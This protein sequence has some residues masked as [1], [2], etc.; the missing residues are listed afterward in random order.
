MATT[1]ASPRP[2]D[3]TSAT[4]KIVNASLYFS[5]RALATAGQINNN[6]ERDEHLRQMNNVHNTINT[7]NFD[8]ATTN[9]N[10][11]SNDDIF[12]SLVPS[13][14]LSIFDTCVE[15][16]QDLVQEINRTNTDDD[17][18][19]NSIKHAIQFLFNENSNINNK[20]HTI[21]LIFL[22]DA[23]LIKGWMREDKNDAI[24]AMK[25]LMTICTTNTSSKIQVRLAQKT[26]TETEECLI[27]EQ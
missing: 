6:T 2:A 8:T 19:L 25:H 14:A 20:T 3:T 7:Y 13:W 18:S 21:A 23:A 27:G 15:Q 4:S 12:R 5:E 10:D 24:K 16:Q 26:C 22:M 1:S 17:N 9:D 11:H